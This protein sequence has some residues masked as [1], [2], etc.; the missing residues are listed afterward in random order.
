M[1]TLGESS[2]GTVLW[3]W[4]TYLSLA[5]AGVILVGLAALLDP[6]E[7][8]REVVAANKKFLLLGALAHC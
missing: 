7:I 8:W 6:K 3:G 1:L 4:Y 2:R 5:I